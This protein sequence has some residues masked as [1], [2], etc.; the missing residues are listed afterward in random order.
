MRFFLRYSI[1]ILIAVVVG[2][3]WA[4]LLPFPFSLIAS[5]ISGAALGYYGYDYALRPTHAT[6]SRDQHG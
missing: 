6:N 5:L 2:I 4:Q 1:V 3:L